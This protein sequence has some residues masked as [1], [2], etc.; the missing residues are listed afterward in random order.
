M[1]TK[2]D[3]IIKRSLTVDYVWTIF[4]EENMVNGAKAKEKIDLE[5]WGKKIDALIRNGYAI[6][7]DNE[8]Y[9]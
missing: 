5:I 2:R 8:Q 1:R 6:R 3:P 9:N 7:H 4:A